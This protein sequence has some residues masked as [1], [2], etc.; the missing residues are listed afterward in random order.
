MEAFYTYLNNTLG[1]V[2]VIG[3]AYT[4]GNYLSLS[5]KLKSYIPLL[6]GGSF[7]LWVFVNIALKPASEKQTRIVTKEQLT[8][9][10]SEHIQ[11]IEIDGVE[12]VSNSKGGITPLLKK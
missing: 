12:Y 3:A 5:G 6:M 11:I 1:V 7:F 9:N 2:L 4:I 10:N 8:V